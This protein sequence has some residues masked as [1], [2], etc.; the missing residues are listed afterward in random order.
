[1]DL[2]SE[3][4]VRSQPELS[5]FAAPVCCIEPRSYSRAARGAMRWKKP[6]APASVFLIPRPRHLWVP[7]STALEN[8]IV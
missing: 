5:H 2:G 4:V 1:M 6:A 8:F 7:P 3:P